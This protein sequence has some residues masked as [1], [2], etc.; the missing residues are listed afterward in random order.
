VYLFDRQARLT[1][2]TLDIPPAEL[3]VSVMQQVSLRR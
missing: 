1:Y 3:V 2:R